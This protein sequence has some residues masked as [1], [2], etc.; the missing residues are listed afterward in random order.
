[1]LEAHA[2]AVSP[3]APSTPFVAVRMGLYSSDRNDSLWQELRT[4]DQSPITYGRDIRPGPHAQATPFAT[5][6][7]AASGATDSM[8]RSR[9]GGVAW[10][11]IDSGLTPN[12]T[13]MGVAPSPRAAG[14]LYGATQRGEVYGTLDG[15]RHW[16]AAPL[17]GGCK[18]VM[19]LRSA[20]LQ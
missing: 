20:E 1:M 14:V 19:A 5:L 8:W 17:P 18:A 13:M 12:G 7:A 16:Y 2:I 6:S 9:D 10:Q 15:G 11:R 4:R 3:A